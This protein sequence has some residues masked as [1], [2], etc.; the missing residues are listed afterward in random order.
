MDKKTFLLLLIF[1]VTLFAAV[2]S[3]YSSSMRNEFVWD[4]RNF[5]MESPYVHDFSRWRE[6]FAHNVGF[7]GGAR[8]NFYRPVYSLLNAANFLA[9]GGQSFIF[10]WTNAFLH[11]ACAALVMTLFFLVARDAFVAFAAALLF[12]VHPV[13]T[14]AVTYIA[15]RADPLY[16]LFA[17][18]SMVFFVTYIRNRA[19]KWTYVLSLSAF[20]A[21]LLSKETAIVTPFYM[22]LIVYANRGAG[23]SPERARLA[24][25]APF[26]LL[27]GFYGVLRL[28]VLDFSKIAHSGLVIPPTAFYAR[29]LTACKAVFMYFRFLFYPAGFQMETYL[30]TARSIAEGASLAAV[31]GVVLL[32]GLVY[33]ANKRDKLVF[34]G[35]A[36]YFMGLLPVLN[37]FPMNANVAVHWLYLPSAG[38]FFVLS[39]I[40][41]RFTGALTA[42][43]GAALGG[44]VFLASVLAVGAV[45]GGVTWKKNAEWRD[46]ETLYKH[47]LLYSRTPRV[48]VNLGN[49]YTRKGDF[50]N[51]VKYYMLAKEIAPGQTEIYVNLGYVYIAKRD[52]S[53][54][55][56][57]LRQGVAI[58]PRHANAHF[59]LGVAYANMGRLQEAVLEIKK[60]LELNPNHTAALNTIGKIYLRLGEAA[61][62]REAFTRS[63]AID[64]QQHEIK[65]IVETLD[66]YRDRGA[67]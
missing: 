49:I 47:V 27:L 11:A 3:A 23:R 25:L 15:G 30:P 14:Q 13:Q 66:T 61:M 53:K 6:L 51:A 9:S 32:A 41:R 31:M 60:T 4:D 56:E 63:L 29:A 5:I 2:F 18:L 35:L 65:K 38:L 19:K 17:L 67:L 10:H 34:F 21:A 57:V 42:G 48:Y 54:A 46:E 33:Y 24:D 37:L 43:R 59:N 40:F 8:N 22:A 20:A 64:A 39:L 62:A 44:S 36:W 55:E 50:D 28:T 26:F 7:S 52:Y 58:S 45:L 12:A 1:S 16:S